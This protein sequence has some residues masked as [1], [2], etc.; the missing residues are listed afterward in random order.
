[1][2]DGANTVFVGNMALVGASNLVTIGK[3][4]DIKMPG[5]FRNMDRA[6]NRRLFGVGLDDTG[7]ALIKAARAQ[8]IA[9]GMYGWL[10]PAV[11]EGAVEEG[12]QSVL[13]SAI[14]D[15]AYAPFNPEYVDGSLSMTEAFANSF[16]D[17]FTTKEGWREIWTGM[18]IGIIGDKGSNLIAGRGLQSGISQAREQ[19]QTMADFNKSYSIDNLSES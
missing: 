18:V 3:A 7:Q 16:E 6:I 9:G 4:F 19:A 12:G 5:A 15:Y 13:S 11:M 14:S 2:Y 8:K 1:L 10:R 17:T